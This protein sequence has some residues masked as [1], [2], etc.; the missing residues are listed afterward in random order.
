HKPALVNAPYI[1]AVVALLAWNLPMHAQL[2]GEPRYTVRDA[3]QRLVSTIGDRPATV[4]GTESPGVVLGTPY[5]NYYVRP[6][7]NSKPGQLTKLGVTHLLTAPN[8]L[9]LKL[10][11]RDFPRAARRMQ[12][13][14]VARVRKLNL[15][16][17][18]LEAEPARAKPARK[19]HSRAS[20]TNAQA[21]PLAATAD[22]PDTPDTR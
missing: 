15:T 19:K 5:H 20:G 18:D 16:L 12:P 6:R 8:D 1:A 2:F 14:W 22:T 3:A 4:V 7:T 10:A 11:R 21:V 17:Y 9:A 13:Q